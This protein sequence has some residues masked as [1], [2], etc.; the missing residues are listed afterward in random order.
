MI[1]LT[2]L[3]KITTKSKKRVGRGQGS[4]KGKNAGKGDKG[5]TKHGGRV[6]IG[7]EGGMRSLMRRMPKFR[8]FSLPEDKQ[9]AVLSTGRISR[10][11]NAGETVTIELLRKKE[12]IGDKVKKVK[13]IQSGELTAGII[14]KD[15]IKSTKGVQGVIK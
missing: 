13:I 9:A 5:Q 1:E 7:F 4:G 12:L 6:R 10:H 14:F 15:K 8:G 11:F 3:P 2:Q